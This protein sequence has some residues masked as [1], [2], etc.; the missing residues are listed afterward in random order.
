VGSL[1]HEDLKH[2]DNYRRARATTFLTIFASFFNGVGN[3]DEEKDSHSERINLGRAG[4]ERLGLNR[5]LNNVRSSGRVLLTGR[6]KLWR[7]AKG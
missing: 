4:V 7:N 5:L 6:W 3:T 2:A 1:L